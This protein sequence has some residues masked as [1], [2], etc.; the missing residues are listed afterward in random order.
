[1]L[2]QPSAKD[3][4]SHLLKF[5]QLQNRGL[6]FLRNYILQTLTGLTQQ[7]QA[8][9][10]VPPTSVHHLIVCTQTS[11][12]GEPSEGGV[13]YLTFKTNAPQI[14]A[15]CVELEKRSS[16][17]EYQA[18]LTDCH[19]SY[20]NQRRQLLLPIINVSLRKLAASTD[21]QATVRTGCAYVVNVC[22]LEYQLFTAFFDKPANALRDFLGGISV[23]LYVAIT[24]I[25]THTHTTLS[26]CSPQ[27]TAMIRC[28]RW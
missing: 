20:F 10:K 2:S 13:L 7:V 6:S 24:N 25:H 15:L 17:P 19:N 8:K 28:V 21:L 23:D 14:K 1:M 16:L 11:P 3:Q 27:R 5:R 9:I 22:C 12:V 18:L 26:S 4:S